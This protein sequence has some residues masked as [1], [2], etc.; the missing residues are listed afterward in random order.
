MKILIFHLTGNANVKSATYGF[1]E[2]GM[3]GEFH[4]T[5]AA[6][7]GGMLDRIGAFG[8][9]AE[10]KRRR[11][12]AVLKPFLHTWP[13][14]EIGRIAAL[15][16]G[17]KSLTRDKT[18]PF[19]IDAVVQNLD[20]HVA[21]R[22]KFA[23]KHGVD[24]VYGYEDTTLFAFR[25]ARKLGIKRIYDLPIGYWRAAHR[26]LQ[27][28]R[29][30][31][32][33]WMATMPGLEA[34]AEKLSRKDEEL[35]LADRIFVASSF[36]ANTL[37]EYPGKLAPVEVIPYGFP[38][39][40][41]QIRT[42]I[43]FKTNRS[44]KLLF[45]GSL[46]QRNGIAD[47]FEAVKEFGDRVS[48]TLVGSK[49]T[50]QCPALD[51]A[52]TRHRWI[53]SLPHHEVLNLMRESDVLVF[54]SLFEGFGLVIT[55]AMSQGTPVITTD[56]TAGPDLIEHGK[57]GWLIAAGSTTALKNCIEHILDNP[58]LIREVGMAAREKARLRPWSC[59]GKE[60]SAAIYREHI[61]V[62]KVVNRY[63]V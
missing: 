4:V 44:L 46:S 26:L 14:F 39:V 18:A 49:T 50:D 17:L 29:E 30:R 58:E 23:M 28:E 10:I 48:L 1:I 3:L 27:G 54:P 47:L 16:T 24:T 60:L 34:S 13:W 61:G 31:W 55:E 52:L 45:V 37:K 20:R 32:P 38:P 9:L 59:Y 35:Q 42:Y 22:L 41:N 25:E 11:F 21:K 6:I 33:E 53:P 12:D 7:P 15:K 56:R 63:E 8:P 40:S 57:N 43:D 5:I 62:E 51:E 19:Y 2:A 36:T